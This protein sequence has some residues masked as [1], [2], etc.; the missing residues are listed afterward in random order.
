LR[1]CT[2]AAWNPA[3]FL[4]RKTT[5]AYFWKPTAPSDEN[6][7]ALWSFA[8]LT[9]NIRRETRRSFFFIKNIFGLL[10]FL[11]A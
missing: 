1:I 5:L 7:F 6:A 9:Y 3:A 11:G 10:R 2:P 4:Y 8:S